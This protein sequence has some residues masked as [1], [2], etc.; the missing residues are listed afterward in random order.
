MY[1]KIFFILLD[2]K[3]THYTFMGFIS[4]DDVSSLI[5]NII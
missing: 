3:D 5:D 4:R 1:Y 2:T